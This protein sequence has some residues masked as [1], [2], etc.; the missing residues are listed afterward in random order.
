MVMWRSAQGG[1]IAGGQNRS[2]RKK[3]VLDA[4]I[5][6]P[7]WVP[8]DDGAFHDVVSICVGDANVAQSLSDEPLSALTR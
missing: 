6:G 3:L 1:E 7:R 5:I 2:P 4:R 8:L